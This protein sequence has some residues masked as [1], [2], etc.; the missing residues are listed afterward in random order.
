MIEFYIAISAGCAVGSIA[1]AHRAA[2]ERLQKLG[3]VEFYAKY[4]DSGTFGNSSLGQSSSPAKHVT[5]NFSTG[6]PNSFVKKSKLI[7]IDSSLK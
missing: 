6:I 2:F 5:D 7:W 4:S 3:V 1:K